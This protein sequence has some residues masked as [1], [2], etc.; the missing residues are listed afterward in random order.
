VPSLRYDFGARALSA[1]SMKIE[2][3]VVMRLQ[4]PRPSLERIGF[5]LA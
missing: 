1:A 4:K 3:M 2:M 5:E